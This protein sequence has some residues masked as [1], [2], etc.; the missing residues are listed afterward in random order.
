MAHYFANLSPNKLKC[1]SSDDLQMDGG[2][3]SRRPNWILSVD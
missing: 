3:R 1:N 2:F